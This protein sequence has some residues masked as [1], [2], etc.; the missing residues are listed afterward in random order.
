MSIKFYA[1]PTCST[2][3]K[4]QRLLNQKKR[5]YDAINITILPPT[6]SELK[7]MLATVGGDLRRLFNTSGKTYREM[8]L[9]AK[10]DTLS[11]GEALK[12]LSSNGTLIKRPFLIVDGKGAAVGFKEQEWDAI[13]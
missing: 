9:G 8:K 2:C 3:V 10:L 7:S 6:M 4:A 13:L 12:L 5:A 1:Y 11:E